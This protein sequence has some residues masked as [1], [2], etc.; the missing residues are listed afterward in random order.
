[1]AT[2]PELLEGLSLETFL[3]RP[4]IDDHPCLEYIN[5]RIVAKLSPKLKHSAI[6]TL[7]AGTINPLAMPMGL[8]Q[9]FTELRCTFD[10]RSIVPDVVFLLEDHIEIDE[11]GEF[12]NDVL[13]PPDIH[14]EIISPKQGDAEADEKLRHSTAHGCSLGWLV[15]PARKTIDVYRPGSGPTRLGVEGILEGEPVLSGFRLPV[16][17]VFEWLTRRRGRGG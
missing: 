17:E 4:K 16:V 11:D 5:G 13:I 1:M 2:A 10:G 9:A 6:Q 3:R 7:L 15:H 12:A 14:V 8:G